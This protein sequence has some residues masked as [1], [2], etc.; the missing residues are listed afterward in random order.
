MKV[1]V[2]TILTTPKIGGAGRFDNQDTK[3]DQILAQLISKPN[4]QSKDRKRKPAEEASRDAKGTMDE[5]EE[6][7]LEEHTGTDMI[8][9][10]L[11]PLEK[12]VLTNWVEKLQKDVVYY[13]VT[14]NRGHWSTAAAKVTKTKKRDMG[15]CN[16]YFTR[17][18]QNAVTGWTTHNLIFQTEE[19]A[20]R[21]AVDLHE[22]FTK[23][24]QGRP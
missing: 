3:L 24:D 22:A 11:R 5:D 15:R 2:P 19:N 17:C 9:D 18:T 12:A 7:L 16:L 23:H 6:D 20:A 1:R 4:Q 13:V 10:A 21:I 14:G 8:D